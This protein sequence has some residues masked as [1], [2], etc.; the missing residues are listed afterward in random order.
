MQM[1]PLFAYSQFDL[2]FQHITDFFTR[3]RDQPVGGA[4]YPD[5]MD[6]SLQGI[7]GCMRHESLKDYTIP[8]AQHVIVQPWP[9]AYALN[10]LYWSA[11]VEQRRDI[12]RQGFRKPPQQRQRG[13]HLA[14]FNL[15]DHAFRALRTL[16]DLSQRQVKTPATG[17]QFDPQFRSGQQ[18]GAINIIEFR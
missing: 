16:C 3:V 18:L 6:I 9:I 1:P 5:E 12:D 14:R 10:H 15:A 13:V 8:L 2:A 11:F 4:A 7:L 17:P